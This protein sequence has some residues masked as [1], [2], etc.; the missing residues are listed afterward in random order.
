MR[1]I[2]APLA[3]V[4]LLSLAGSAEAKAW[5]GIVPMVSTRTNVL[6]ALGDGTDPKDRGGRFDFQNENV[7]I[8]YSNDHNSN[9]CV[10]RLPA[11]LVIQ[12]IVIPKLQVSVESLGLDQKRLTTLAPAPQAPLRSEALIDDDEGIIVSLKG[13][14]EQ[15]VYV[16]TKKD[17]ELCPAYYGDLSRFVKQTFLCILCP[18]ISVDCPEETEAGNKVNFTAHVVVGSPPLEL[19][20]N[21][22]VSEGNILEGQGTASISVDSNK[23]EGKTMTA[24]V[25][26][27]GID[28][29]CPR[30]AS[31]G[32]KILK[33]RTRRP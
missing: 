6:Q 18:T 15:I 13:A 17:R 4:F 29:S 7:F 9:E 27:S 10:G 32:A 28:P 22:T 20:F 33:Q 5:R 12:I 11:D 26:V 21:W 25:E 30:T 23:L 3:T 14:V 2:T 24:T 31:C 1:F 8:V 19:T 16:A